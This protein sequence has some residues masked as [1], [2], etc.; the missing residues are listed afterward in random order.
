M[1]LGI[2]CGLLYVHLRLWCYS[3]E[4]D[5]EIWTNSLILNP[6]NG[7]P[8]DMQPGGPGQTVDPGKFYR[9]VPGAI[10]AAK[11]YILPPD[12]ALGDTNGPPLPYSRMYQTALRVGESPGR[13]TSTCNLFVCESD[14]GRLALLCDTNGKLQSSSY[15]LKVG[16][17]YSSNFLQAPFDLTG[18]EG[19]RFFRISP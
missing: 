4:L 12:F 17:G 5:Y 11:P 7:L 19:S 3:R 18:R 8:I 16:Q 10:G 2:T 9:I 1:A 14:R 6:D 15:G 13:L